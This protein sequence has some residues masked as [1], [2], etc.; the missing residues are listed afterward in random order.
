MV[1]K[2]P[3]EINI[4]RQAG[5][6][7]SAVRRIVLEAAQPGLTTWELDQLAER[8]MEE[9]GGY[10]SFKGFDGFPFA[11]CINLNNGVVHGY[12]SKEVVLKRGDLF[13]V[14][15]GL[16]Y[17]GFHSDA[18]ETIVVGGRGSSN[19]VRFLDTGRLALKRAIAKCKVG[20]FLGDVSHAIQEVI[21]E[22]GYSV[23]KSLV[24]HGIG[25][26][27]HEPPQIPGYGQAGSRPKLEVGAALAIEVIYNQGG[28]EVYI[29]EDGW[30]V[31][32][33]DGSNSAIFEHTVAVTKEGP[34]V[35]TL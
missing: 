5:K 34:R 9:R 26:D 13:T 3:E 2:S 1:L 4:M 14:D 8:E 10:P 23:V 22:Q 11:T 17:N 25:K 24:G 32:T 29:A 7:N 15:L 28:D 31:C 20:N 21:E 35:L 27:L 12:P 19:K 30:T 16:L 33:A 6:I 18:A